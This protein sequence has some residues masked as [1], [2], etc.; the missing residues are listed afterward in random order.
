[1]KVWMVGTIE[2]LL[3][4]M[5][6]TVFVS[7]CG[8]S[9]PE[10]KSNRPKAQVIGHG[11]QPGSSWLGVGLTLPLP[12]TNNSASSSS[13]SSSGEAQASDRFNRLSR[14]TRAELHV[15]SGAILEVA[16]G[17]LLVEH[18]SMRAEVVGAT[19]DRVEL[20]FTYLGPT[21]TTV[22]LGSGE[23]RR[24][25]GVK[26]RA[27]DTCNVLYVM[28]HIEPSQ[29]LAVSI[30][31]NEGQT[32]HEQCRDRGYTNLLPRIIGP[33][34]KVEIGAP[35]RLRAEIEDQHLTVLID[36]QVAWEGFVGEL[37]GALYGP[38]GIRSD[39]GRFAFE[40]ATERTGF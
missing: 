13:V 16:P 15:T 1:M 10:D 18:P 21:A 34:P 24:Q 19:A 36:D 5:G 7:G 23:L 11:T 38:V 31:R 26:L 22:P 37:T 9:R 17:E 32:R 29:N 4:L 20:R 28:W 3:C 39:N 27:Q 8:T 6:L 40:V 25:F 14:L 2:V 30:K 33:V 35:H 12:A